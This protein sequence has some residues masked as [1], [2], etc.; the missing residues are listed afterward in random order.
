[1]TAPVVVNCKVKLQSVRR[2]V[3]ARAKDAEKEDTGEIETEVKG[4]LSRNNGIHKRQHHP[5]EDE[6]KRGSHPKQ[7]SEAFFINAHL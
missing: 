2:G 3:Y 7:Q 5:S 6:K 1:M 4:G